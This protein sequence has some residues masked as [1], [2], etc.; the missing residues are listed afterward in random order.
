MMSRVEHKTSSCPQ[1]THSQGF[2]QSLFKLPFS[3]SQSLFTGL[4]PGCQVGGKHRKLLV[5][6]QLTEE[7]EKCHHGRSRSA[8]PDEQETSAPLF[9]AEAVVMLL[10]YLLSPRFRLYL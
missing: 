7:S 4:S 1:V 3:M 6:H 9:E 2:S 10:S 5:G 8:C